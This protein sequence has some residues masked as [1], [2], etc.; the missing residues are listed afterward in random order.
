[1]IRENNNTRINE[2]RRTQKLV[3]IIVIL[4][5]VLRVYHLGYQDIWYDE[6]GSIHQATS[7]LPTLFSG[8]HLSPLYYLILR[9]WIKL[10]G[11]SEFSLRLPS[12]IFGIASVY[13]IYK[14][15]KALFD[16]WVGVI[17]SFILAISPF[18]LFYSQ[19]A[20][21]YSLFL[22]LTL[23]S[24]LFSLK[25]IENKHTPNKAY[26]FY[27][28]STIMLLYTN[29]FGLFILAIQNVFFLLKRSEEK[30]K[31]F[32]TQ[33]LILVIFLFWLIPFNTFLSNKK[34]YVNACINWIP[35][36][37]INSLLDVFKTFSYGGRH[38][39]GNDIKIEPKDIGFSPAIFFILVFL[40]ILG[41]ISSKRSGFINLIFVNLWLFTPVLV[42][43]IFSNYLFSLFLP[44]YFIFVLPAYYIL[45]SRGIRILRNNTIQI[46]LIYMIAVLMLPSLYVYYTKDLKMRWSQ[47]CDY[48]EKNKS[49]NDAIIVSPGHLV[50]MFSYYG[51]DGIRKTPFQDKFK[52]DVIND[53]GLDMIKGG[54]VYTKGSNKLIGIADYDQ[55]I[56]L[57]K[58]GILKNNSH[59]WLILARWTDTPE[60]I[61]EYAASK[62]TV[63]S[64]KRFLGLDVYYYVHKDGL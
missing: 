2:D 37:N 3:F 25:L 58:R 54:F 6:V 23:L 60:Q 34:E 32:R 18:H 53:L 14:L 20:R 28:A 24:M 50:Q 43:L 42:I 12:A 8:F 59:F 19:E 40:F 4:A 13:L 62:F 39:G 55:F 41:L 22:L 30:K 17:S 51:Q 47:A 56:E 26:I 36:P 64:E 10:F 29:I 49:D 61:K 5:A 38:Y 48:I 9:F 27:V 21:H 35:K 16:K 45:I 63:K 44:R 11:I 33:L 46:V 1:M 7:N 31:W 15:G 57:F 52:I